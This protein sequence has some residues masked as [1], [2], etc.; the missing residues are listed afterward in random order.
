MFL[1]EPSQQ[2]KQLNAAVEKLAEQEKH[3]RKSVVADNIGQ[4]QD[5]D[6]L[7]IQHGPKISAVISSDYV[8]SLD[9]RER[10]PMARSIRSLEYARA[11]PMLT[12][13]QYQKKNQEYK[14]KMKRNKSVTIMVSSYWKKETT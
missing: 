5:R 6:I 12:V 13:E 3:I 14:M 1:T 2:F 4:V 10:F 11:R 8:Q 7:Q 9:M